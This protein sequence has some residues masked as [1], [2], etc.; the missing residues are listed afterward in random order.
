MKNEEEMKMKANVFL[1]SEIPVHVD[2]RQGYWKNGKI[3]EVSSD[4]FLLE[5]RLEGRMP[6]FFIE[7]NDI[8]PFKE[9]KKEV[10][11]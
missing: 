11:K 4:F 5:E 2:F 9:I 3:L 10:G 7:I 8:K 6:I 1:K